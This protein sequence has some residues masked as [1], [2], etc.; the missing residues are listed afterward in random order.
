MEK[1]NC[2]E[3]P[4]SGRCPLETVMVYANENGGKLKL[5]D[6]VKDIM[7]SIHPDLSTILLADVGSEPHELIVLVFALGYVLGKGATPIPLN[8]SP[9]ESLARIVKG[10]S[11]LEKYQE[12]KDLEVHLSEN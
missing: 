2:N 9:L 3:C 8:E 12:N 10:I 7:D 11:R 1:H 5:S 6:E 4:K